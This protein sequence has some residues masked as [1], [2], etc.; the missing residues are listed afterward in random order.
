MSESEA[1]EILEGLTC[2]ACTNS[3]CGFKGQDRAP[4]KNCSESSQHDKVEQE[5]IPHK[6]V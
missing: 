2:A 3:S 5:P 1:H 4:S 6:V